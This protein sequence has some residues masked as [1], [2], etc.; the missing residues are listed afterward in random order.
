MSV[1]TVTVSV[2]RAHLMSA[3]HR[4]H[5]RTQ[6]AQTRVLRQLAWA[7]ARRALGPSCVPSQLHPL[8]VRA[9]IDVHVT[10]PDR[11]RRDVANVHPTV[12]ALVDGLV[13]DA[14]LLPDD[15]DEHLTGPFLHPTHDRTGVPGLTRFRIEIQEQP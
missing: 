3:N 13:Q 6:R 11:R 12:K 10:W 8:M 1:L 9:Q 14:H 4:K 15:D 2:H 7:E 5:W